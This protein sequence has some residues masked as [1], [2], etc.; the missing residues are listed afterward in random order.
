MSQTKF[1]P[2]VTVFKMYERT[3]AKGNTY[4][5]GSLGLAQIVAFRS[6]EPNEHGQHVWEFK[7]Q[8]RPERRDPAA[9]QAYAPDPQPK[10]ASEARNY[11]RNLDEPIPF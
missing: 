7:F 4:L 9:P 11:E 2:S 10:Q 8:E 1:G 6:S 3:S 5:A